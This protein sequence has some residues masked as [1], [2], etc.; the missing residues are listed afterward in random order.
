MCKHY[1]VYEPPGGRT[2]KGHCIQCGSDIIGLN[3]FP[4]NEEIKDMEYQVKNEGKI[5]RSIENN[6]D[7]ILEG[8]RHGKSVSRDFGY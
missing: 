6:T 5:K 1:W 8:S 2:S 3:S 4:D 7:R